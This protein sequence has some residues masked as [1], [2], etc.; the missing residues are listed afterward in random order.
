[1]EEV[2]K[3]QEALKEEIEKLE[4]RA[5]ARPRRF[6]RPPGEEL[7]DEETREMLRTLMRQNRR[8]AE[9]VDYLLQMLAEAA[10]GTAEE[11]MEKMLTTIA[12]A[13]VSVLEQIGKVSEIK[14]EELGKVQE[15]AFRVLASK[16]DE[17][18]N[19][20]SALPYSQQMDVLKNDMESISS[21]LKAVESAVKASPQQAAATVTLLKEDLASL[22]GKLEQI[23]SDIRQVGPG[24]ETVR[25]KQ[26]EIAVALA[27]V[28]SIGAK[29]SS[30]ESK[31]GELSKTATP[32]GVAEKLG[33]IE[34]EIRKLAAAP[35][36]TEQL[37]TVSAGLES[38]KAEL[39]SLGSRESQ[40][41]REKIASLD[42]KLSLI[43]QAGE[44]LS[45]IEAK[46]SAVEETLKTPG[47][48]SLAE[49]RSEFDE[50]KSMIAS[51]REHPELVEKM[52][53][54]EERLSAL[55]SL[56]NK[57]TLLQADIARLGK[58]IQA[59][60]VHRVE[61]FREAKQELEKIKEEAG[62]HPAVAALEEKVKA[63]EA[64]AAVERKAPR[65]PHIIVLIAV[66][67]AL[68]A[69][70]LIFAR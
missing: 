51:A 31:L 11:D 70:I 49:L 69:L 34:A 55:A 6:M 60:P 10:E 2:K 18:R 7:E 37:G 62:E 45:A 15:E 61:E 17:I 43:A 68:A 36:G 20:I 48:A 14:P 9:R 24:V 52:G 65:I 32:A 39:S 42:E 29:L 54:F 63:M 64:P 53:E 50:I 13:Q 1:M 35:L 66:A 46:L 33:S 26:D 47:A 16:L 12:Q 19:S 22:R 25:L 41:I 58:E 5:R 21:E 67:L 28:S 4:E 27:A 23:S 3:N 30:L 59:Y 57:I 40:S 8:L 56:E 44:K 38:L